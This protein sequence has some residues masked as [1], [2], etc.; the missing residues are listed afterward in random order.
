MSS[1]R[2]SRARIAVVQFDP[3]LCMVE[4]N[5][6][7][8]K[9]LCSGL[10]PGSVDL[11]C[12]S[13]MAFSGYVFPDSIG[14]DP[15]LD[16]P[17]TGLASQF[18]SELAAHLKC[19][20]IGGFPERLPKDEIE[21]GVD[22]WGGEMIRVGASSA[23][24][25]GPDGECVGTYRKTNLFE[26]DSV[27]A[28]PGTGFATFNLPPPLNSITL[29][30]GS[31]LNVP[32]PREWTSL[33]GPYELASRCISDK[34]N[35]LILLNAWLELPEEANEDKASTTMNFWAQRLIPLWETREGVA[36]DD[37]QEVNVIICNRTGTETG[38]KFCGSSCNFQMI[39][40]SGKPKLVDAMGK[41]EEGIRVWE[42]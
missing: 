33:E 20:V 34:S 28:K 41:D 17:L 12:F 22:D 32:R 26:I 24:L 11:V 29:G 25:Y 8:A 18:C 3:Q 38:K 30:I 9:S 42:V 40:S 10:T 27:W 15:F 4:E 35:L 13:E 5:I 2:T 21:P 36:A 6:E 31:D 39:R 23:I 19:Y 1:N 16:E 14:I 7:K 37:G